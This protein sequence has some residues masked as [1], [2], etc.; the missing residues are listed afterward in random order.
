MEV[1]FYHQK[2]NAEVVSRTV[3]QKQHFCSWEC[4]NVHTGKKENRISTN[5][6]NSEHGRVLRSGCENLK[7]YFE[8]SCQRVHPV[9]RML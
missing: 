9:F 2:L 1:G 7:A 8:H 3:K 4:L 6:R 5:N